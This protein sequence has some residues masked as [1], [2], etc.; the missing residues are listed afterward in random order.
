MAENNQE[1]KQEETSVLGDI[2][3]QTTND[4]LKPKALEVANSAITDII[5]AVG[6]W[7]VGIVGK[8]IFGPDSQYRNG[9]NGNKRGTDYNKLSQSPNANIG[10]RAS[11]DL[12]EVIFSTESEAAG[13]RNEMIDRIRRYGK[14]SV[15]FLYEKAH[16][17]PISSDYRYGWNDERDIHYTRNRFGFYFDLPKPKPIA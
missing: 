16:K 9:R 15:G 2:I 5:Y 10:L 7:L 8:K 4:I 6:D 14:V 1:Q 12:M 17:Q 13:V 11:D 3:R